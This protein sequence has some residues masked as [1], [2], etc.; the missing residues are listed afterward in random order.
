MLDHIFIGINTLYFNSAK[1]EEL[2][3]SSQWLKEFTILLFPAK[4][5]ECSEG[6]YIQNHT[7]YADA[8]HTKK[9]FQVIGVQNQ[10]NL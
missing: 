7:F 6:Q 10:M 2:N 9:S 3:I 5:S 1:A 8:Y 4:F